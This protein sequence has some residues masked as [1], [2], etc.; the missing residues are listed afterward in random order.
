M[1]K[2]IIAEFEGHTIKVSNNWF[3]GSKL[4]VDDELLDSSNEFF[5]LDP[6][7]VI[8]SVSRGADRIEVFAYAIFTT[9]MK[10]CVNGKMIGGEEF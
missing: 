10:I 2:T 8:M 7:K 1:N 4:Y 3:T 5:A 9:K 6:N